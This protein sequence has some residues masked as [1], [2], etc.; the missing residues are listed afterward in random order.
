MDASLPKDVVQFDFKV[1]EAFAFQ[2]Q[3]ACWVDLHLGI[4][5]CDLLLFEPQFQLKPLPVERSSYHG[6]PYAYN[7][8][9]YGIPYSRRRRARDVRRATERAAARPSV[10]QENVAQ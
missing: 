9:M 10:T 5:T 7:T 6:H 3:W 2:D 8:V 4:L 1:D